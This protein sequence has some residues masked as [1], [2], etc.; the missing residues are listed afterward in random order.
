MTTPVHLYDDEGAGPFVTG[1]F[2][3]RLIERGHEVRHIKAADVLA[4]VLDDAEVMV[5]PGGAD[6]PYI[7]KLGDDGAARIRDFVHGGG[8][9]FGSCA[10]GYYAARRIT[11]NAPGFDVDEPRPLGFYPGTAHGPVPGIAPPFRDHPESAAVVRLKA[12]SELGTALFW[13]GFSLQPDT[14]ATATPI[15][16]YAANALIAAASCTIGNGHVVVSGVHPEVTGDD[17][18]SLKDA[19]ATTVD[20]L[21]E[22]EVQR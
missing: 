16:H 12:G 5:L 10:G 7:R 22:H 21:R 19:P 13:G 6:R 2:E 4:G 9:F 11:F 18:A 15:G 1:C 3:R 17:F 8:R 14:D 20:L